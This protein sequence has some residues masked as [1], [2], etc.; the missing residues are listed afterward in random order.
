MLT[1]NP[2]LWTLLCSDMET[3]GSF[4]LLTITILKEFDD[5]LQN[6]NSFCKLLPLINIEETDASLFKNIRLCL[7]MLIFPN[8]F[9]TFTICLKWNV[10]LFW[11]Y[12]TEERKFEIYVKILHYNVILTGY[13]VCL[14]SLENSEN[15]VYR[16]T[17]HKNRKH[18]ILM[19]L[20]HKCHTRLRVHAF[21]HKGS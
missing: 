2:I 6:W 19:L 17:N 8:L 9:N 12:S 20:F 18:E 10:T 3:K 11:K 15:M 1:L 14:F 7:N 5:I 13:T 16:I 4:K 21:V